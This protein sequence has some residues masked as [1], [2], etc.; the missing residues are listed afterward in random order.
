MLK[1]LLRYC[2]SNRATLLL[3]YESTDL[4]IT[5]T[6]RMKTTSVLEGENCTFECQ[7]SHDLNDE[8]SWTINGQV[9]VTNSRIQAVNN[10]RRYKMT[11]RDAVLS[12]AGDV[13]FAIKDLSCRTMLF[14]KGEYLAASDKMYVIHFDIQFGRCI[15]TKMPKCAQMHFPSFREAGAHFQG[16][17]EC[18]GCAGRGCRAEL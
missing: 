8:P 7:L 9:V 15:Y 16:P 17:A 4:H 12:D 2:N 1:Q 10:G 18:Q 3:L 11:I 14:V 13:V 5:I 6:Q